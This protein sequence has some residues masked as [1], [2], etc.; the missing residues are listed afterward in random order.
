MIID[1]SRSIIG[2]YER[3]EREFSS[4]FAEMYFI[5]QENRVLNVINQYF[6]ILIDTYKDNL[7]ALI[8]SNFP[9]VFKILTCID[10]YAIMSNISAM[11][12]VDD[13]FTKGK[14]KP[15]EGAIPLLKKLASSAERLILDNF[16]AAIEGRITSAEDIEWPNL[17]IIQE[18]FAKYVLTD[19]LMDSGYVNIIDVFNS[20]NTIVNEIEDYDTWGPLLNLDYEME[21]MKKY[22]I[23]LEDF[24]DWFHFKHFDESLAMD[25]ILAEHEEMESDILKIENWMLL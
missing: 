20:N 25:K 4:A 14:I 3:L 13:S 6:P 18:H 11:F 22:G 5:E 17:V 10:T 23:G 8:R 2:D 19:E 9:L 12:S 21:V 15:A 1:F 24:N 7:S 16:Q